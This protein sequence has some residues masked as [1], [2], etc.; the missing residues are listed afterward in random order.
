MDTVLVRYLRTGQFQRIFRARQSTRT[1]VLLCRC[2]EIYKYAPE[3]ISLVVSWLSLCRTTA[4]AVVEPASSNM[5]KKTGR[6]RAPAGPPLFLA[7]ERGGGRGGGSGRGR[8]RQG[9][10]WC[11]P[12]PLLVLHH[13]RSRGQRT[14]PHGTAHHSAKTRNERRQ[15]THPFLQKGP[16]MQPQTGN[17]STR[18]L[19]PY[20]SSPK[21]AR[22]TQNK[23]GNFSTRLLRQCSPKGVSEFAAKKKRGKSLPD[24][25]FA[26]AWIGGL[27]EKSWSGKICYLNIADY[28]RKGRAPRAAGAIH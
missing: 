3:D 11:N 20:S 8:Y 5:D 12:L 2:Q 1:V 24:T 9:R 23:T 26:A 15:H 14:L 21:L 18:L 13:A 22:I 16:W 4:V 6:G 10:W 7:S 28:Q 25:N 27:G 17:S 19:S